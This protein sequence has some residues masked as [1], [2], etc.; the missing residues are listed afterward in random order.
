MTFTSFL[1]PTASSG[2]A[3]FALRRINFMDDNPVITRKPLYTAKD[4]FINY[5]MDEIS[6]SLESGDISIPSHLLTA[7]EMDAWIMSL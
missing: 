6:N 1:L 5:P 7:D 4:T 2:Q 3:T